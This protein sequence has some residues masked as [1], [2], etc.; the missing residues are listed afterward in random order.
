MSDFLAALGI[1]LIFLGLFALVAQSGN[2]VI[3]R[4]MRKLKYHGVDGQAVYRRH[5]YGNARARRVYFDVCLPEGEPPVEFHE[6][7]RVPPGIEGTVVPV[8]YDSRKPKR[9]KTGTRADLD[10]DE[11]RL[12]VLYAGGGGLVLL[13]I[14]TVLLLIGAVV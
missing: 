2:F 8:V 5:E 9:A 12:V 3:Y 1:I 10:F 11:E 13:G 7:M 4:Q 6:Y 14:G